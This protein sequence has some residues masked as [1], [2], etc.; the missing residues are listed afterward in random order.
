MALRMARGERRE[1]PCRGSEIDSLLISPMLS[2]RSEVNV[3]LAPRY[4]ILALVASLNASRT[5]GPSPLTSAGGGVKCW[6]GA[7]L[8]TPELVLGNGIPDWVF[9]NF[10]E[11]TTGFVLRKKHGSALISSAFPWSEMYRGVEVKRYINAH[12]GGHVWGGGV[13]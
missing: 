3:A 8:P 10:K 5:A 4:A 7:E 13:E 2:S 1:V 6:T 11:E 9:S 12:G